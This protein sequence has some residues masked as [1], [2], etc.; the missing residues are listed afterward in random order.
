[1]SPTQR[2]LKDV[3]SLGFTA[4]V[5]EKWNP[6][7]HIRQDLFGIIDIVAVMPGFGILG[8]QATSGSNHAA[9]RT[10]SV[11]EPRLATW[12]ASGGRFEIW[13]YAQQGA[14][15]KRKLWTLRREEIKAADMEC[16]I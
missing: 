9:R 12:L 7:A 16:K 6:F 14:R 15:G 13:S 11:A 5:V 4:Q 2:A 1:M 10:K 3:R 8:I